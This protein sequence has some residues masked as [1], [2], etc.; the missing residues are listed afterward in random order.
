MY[1]LHKSK[2]KDK[3][4]A[5]TF[6]ISGQKHTV[7]FGH[8][9]YED[10]TI[11]KD[12]KRRRNYL[13]RS[14]GIRNG[15]GRLTKDDPLSPNYWARRILWASREPFRGIDNKLPPLKRSTR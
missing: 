8:P 11:H 1:K 5:A 15:S 4:M 14:A 7:H 2:R 12:P 3:K 13:T 9:A 10:Y 6:Y